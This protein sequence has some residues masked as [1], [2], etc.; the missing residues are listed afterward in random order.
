MLAYLNSFLFLRAFRRLGL[1]Y[2]LQDTDT[3]EQTEGALFMDEK[4]RKE[5]LM[6]FEDT[7][8]D[9]DWNR[10]TDPE[11]EAKHREWLKATTGRGKKR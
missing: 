2:E 1:V 10:R 7:V 11:E 9:P 6:T 4:H 5:D 8:S 3:G